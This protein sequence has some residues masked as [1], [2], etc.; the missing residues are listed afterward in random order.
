MIFLFNGK[1]IANVIAMSMGAKHKFNSFGSFP[2]LGASGVRFDPRID[3]YNG[4][5]SRFNIESRMA[6]PLKCHPIKM[7]HNCL[8]YTLIFPQAVANSNLFPPQLKD[9]VAAT[10]L[11][12]RC[13]CSA[14]VHPCNIRRAPAIGAGCTTQGCCGL[15]P[16][17]S[18]KR[19]Q[20]PTATWFI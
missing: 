8:L 18:L 20:R 9:D 1:S 19:M 7:R 12:G 3:H 15:A 16:M 13:E 14:P 2:A 11:K 17:N 4:S 6:Q 5:F 10:P